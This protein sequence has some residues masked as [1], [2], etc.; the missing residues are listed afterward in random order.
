MKNAFF[1]TFTLICAVLLLHCGGGEPS[2]PTNFTI[3]AAE[4][5][6]TVALSWDEP[7]TGSPDNYVV[8][9]QAVDATEFTAVDTVEDLTCIHDPFTR[10][11]DYYIAAVFG[12][13]EEH[14]DTLTTIP[15]HTP[16][17]TLGELNTSYDAAYGWD[18]S[19]DFTGHT[20][21]MFDSLNIPYIDFYVTELKNGPW[22]TPYYVSSPTELGSDFGATHVPDGDWRETW[23]TNPL[24]NPQMYLPVYATTTYFRWAEDLTE[25]SLF[26]GVYLEG[27]GYFALVKFSG[28]GVVDS[29]TVQAETWFQ[30]VQGL[31]LIAH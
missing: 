25:D 28:F 9:F 15:V 8:Y 17:V 1:L 24:S 21:S 3:A 16:Q 27:E 20:F 14:S 4:N 13:T 18:L 30:S 5:G 11:G 29:F 19:G 23:F 2:P 26:I 6:I 7:E 12:D 31:R 22:S 10:T